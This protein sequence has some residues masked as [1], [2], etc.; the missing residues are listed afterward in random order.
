M[1]APEACE[2]LAD[3]PP[4]VRPFEHLSPSTGPSLRTQR[5][6]TSRIVSGMLAVVVDT[7]HDPGIDWS[8]RFRADM[9]A[10]A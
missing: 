3:V 7:L 4:L 5:G 2:M 1:L 9:S 6:T 8:S 10:R